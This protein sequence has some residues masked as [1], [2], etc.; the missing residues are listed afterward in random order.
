MAQAEAAAAACERARTSWREEWPGL[1]IGALIVACVATWHAA[2][3]PA[4]VRERV[5]MLCWWANGAWLWGRRRAAP[6]GEPIS[7]EFARFCRPVLA[8]LSFA[9]AIVMAF[10]PF[11]L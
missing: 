5:L 8:V 7:E 11:G 9:T 1:L 3:L 4:E 6:P 10:G 2:W